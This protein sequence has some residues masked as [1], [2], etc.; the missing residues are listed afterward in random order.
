MFQPKVVIVAF[1]TGNDPLESFQMV[2][3]NSHWNRLIPD[4]NLTA[5]DMPR[6]KFPAPKSEWWSVSFADGVKTVFTPT[7]RL[8]SNS[9]DKAVHAGYSIMAEV[10]SQ[11]LNLAKPNN[12]QMVF[13]IIPSKEL[14]YSKKVQRENLQAPEVYQDLVEL[15]LKN[16]QRLADHIQQLDGAVYVDLVESMQTGALTREPLYPKSINGHPIAAGY[17]VIAETMAHAVRQYSNVKPKGLYAVNVGNGKYIRILA[18]KRS[19]WVFASQQMLE[20]NGWS[21]NGIRIMSSRDFATLAIKG[22]VNHVDQ[23]LFGPP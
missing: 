1:Y 19:A 6:A 14:V 22:Y 23:L 11:M 17:R 20:A 18:K 9:R 12:V 15:E 5:K 2:Y 8:A 7:L 16:I 13:T 10:A 4:K 21:T 3:G